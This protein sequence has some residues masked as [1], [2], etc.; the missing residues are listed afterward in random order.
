[1]EI[2][3]VPEE[4]LKQKAETLQA[5]ANGP[6]ASSLSKLSVSSRGIPSDKDFHF[7]RNF[8]EFKVPMKE[9][10]EKSESLLKSIGSSSFLLGKEMTF[11]KDS[12]EAYEWL[13]NV[14]DEVIERCDVSM[15]EFS[16]LRKKEEDV[17]ERNSSIS[18][19]DGFQLVYG[20]KKKVGSHS[21]E[22]E[23]GQDSCP[24]TSVKVASRDK[25]TTGAKPRVP[26][27]I[28]SIVRP[29]DE[30]KIMVN[31]SNQPFEHVWLKRSGD[32]SRFIHPLEEFSVYDFVDRNIG[33]VEPVKPLP[34]ESTPFKLIEEVKD[35]KELAA[36]LQNVDE[37][38]V[39][40]EHNQYRSF[41]G[42]TCLM[43]ISTRSEDYVVDTL[44]LR[45]LIGPHL[46]ELFKDPS[47]KKVM[48]GADRDILWLQ[49]DFGIYVCNLF[50]TGQASR[51]LQLERNSLEYLLHHFCGVTANKEYQNADWRLRL[52]PDEMLRYAR[53]DTHYLLHI[54]D[55]MRARLLSARA[56]SESG[57]DL[58]L[59]VYRRSYEIC[60]QL[61]EK[62]LLTDTSY[63]YIYGLGGADFNAQQ[64]AIVAGLC[65]W[66]DAVARAEDESTGYIL[67]N[68]A[69]LDIARH[70]PLNAGKL[71][72]LVRSKHPYVERNL[73]SV[74]IIIENSI[75]NA[76][77]F[78][79]AA[80]QLK[81]GRQE[82]ESDENVKVIA[83][84]SEALPT[85]GIPTRMLTAAAETMNT[86]DDYDNSV[87]GKIGECIAA[88]VQLKEEPL[89]LVGNAFESGTSGKGGSFELPGE[90]GKIKNE[91]DFV[92]KPPTGSPALLAQMGDTNIE[93]SS[94]TSAKPVTGA[95]IQM[96]KKPSRA[97][98]ALLGN[99]TSKRKLN[100]E[101]K[102]NA[103]MKVEKIKS[104]VNLPFHSFS[105]SDKQMKP[106]FQE[107][108]KPVE[109]HPSEPVVTLAEANNLEDIISLEC[110]LDDEK[111]ADGV[112]KAANDALHPMENDNDIGST[113]E[114]DTGDEPTSLS[115]LS[116]SFQKCFQSINHNK[117][118]GQVQSSR[119]YEGLQ[120]KPFDYAAARNELKF[121]EGKEAEGEGKSDEGR[122]GLV[123]SKERR[124]SS[125]ANS[126]PIDEGANDNQQPRRRQA[127]PVTG[128]RS[129][130]FR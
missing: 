68:K 35:L 34:I 129:A 50:D 64:L 51:V 119:E 29:Q 97:F 130:T 49:R 19:E 12:E 89:E 90:A 110:G 10:A 46:R 82:T 63:L 20:K 84:E 99:S 42:M 92:L 56:E 103:E 112:P 124:K 55:L 95:T 80:E 18:S 2:D 44:K 59:E 94:R 86:N 106:F 127:F 117:N 73:S 101:Q 100:P 70:I 15:D 91:Q 26:F 31:N 114:P 39:D 77:A 25:K 69:L 27:H 72:R 22:T 54:Y 7:F 108:K 88:P 16:R 109:I 118:N 45:V 32:G 123:G 75:Q 107:C 38:A 57:D 48:H 30:H 52:L 98:G 74:L 11:P 4:T 33:D 41:Q 66:R 111:S 53:E 14:S 13:V 120:L 6:L 24:V 9:I 36:K 126:G 81:K 37:F 40:L 23:K 79:N 28:P 71:R 8:D 96:L 61:Y 128:N 21:M 43:Q 116:S 115:D 5:L 87:N 3:S 83:D 121:G 1:M 125:A 93:M 47:K 85:M 76:A 122:R 78:E 102:D 60:M 65:E 58:L 105:G 67:P 113:L 62:E 17:G 104:S